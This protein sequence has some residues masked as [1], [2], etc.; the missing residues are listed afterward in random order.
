[1]PYKTKERDIRGVNEG[2]T[3]SKGTDDN[4]G[5][6]SEAGEDLHGDFLVGDDGNDDVEWVQEARKGSTRAAHFK[7]PVCLLPNKTFDCNRT[8]HPPRC[9]H[10]VVC[11][12]SLVNSPRPL[13]ISSGSLSAMR[14]I[15]R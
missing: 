6:N 14:T 5:D 13:S 12:I 7:V 9:S 15:S 8:S 2:N 11:Q 1:M 10:R 4:G 3:L